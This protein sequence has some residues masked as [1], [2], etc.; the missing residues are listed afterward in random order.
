MTTATTETLVPHGTWAVDAVHSNANFEVEHSGVSAFRGGFK[1]VDAKLVSSD[2]TISLE[3]GVKV[4][5]ITIDDENIRPHVLSPDF[6]DAERNPDITFRST[7][8]S[9]SADDLTVRG[10]LALAG[11]TLPVE[12]RGRIR[13]PVDGPTGQKLALSLAATIDRTAYGMNWQMEMPSGGSILAN[14]VKL[15]VDLELAPA[16]D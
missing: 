1:P 10:D 2:D 13:G 9:G 11:V 3:G 15:I 14:D 4:D 7:E 16:E 5:T 6:F 12:A 8:I